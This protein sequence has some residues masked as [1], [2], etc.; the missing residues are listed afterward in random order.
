MERGIIA[1][2]WIFLVSKDWSE[3]IRKFCDCVAEGENRHYST[4]DSAGCTDSEK[5]NKIY[6]YLWRNMS[7]INTEKKTPERNVWSL[8]GLEWTRTT[9][10]TLIRRAL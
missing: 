3:R 10:L 8:G 7:Y 1:T 4:K 2:L 5:T 6:M 9:D